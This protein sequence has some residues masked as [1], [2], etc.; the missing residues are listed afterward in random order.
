MDYENRTTTM[1]N[2]TTRKYQESTNSF[3]FIHSTS[4]FEAFVFSFTHIKVLTENANPKKVIFSANAL[5]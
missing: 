4:S 1:Q 3:F 5:S 2:K